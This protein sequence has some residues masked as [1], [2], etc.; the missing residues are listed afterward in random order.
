MFHD[1]VLEHKIDILHQGN[2]LAN[3]GT[4]NDDRNPLISLKILVRPCQ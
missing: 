3:V 1:G 4:W 2:G